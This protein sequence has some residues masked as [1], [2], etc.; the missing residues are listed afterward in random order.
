L[1]NDGLLDLFVTNGYV[2]DDRRSSYWY[3]FSKVAGGHKD[4]ISDAAHWP[5]MEGRSLSGYQLKKLWLNS[6]QWKFQQVAQA[7]GIN[8]TYDGRAVALVDLWNRGV[9]DVVVAHQRGPLLVYKNTTAA[10][11]D[12]I[13]FDLEGT[14]SNSSAIGTRVEVHW[15][16]QVQL[17]QVS[18]GMGFCSQNQR[19]LQFGLGHDAVVEKV[20]ITWPSGKSQTL[21]G[22]QT[23]TIHRLVEAA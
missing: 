10:D 14:E 5:A 17:Q 20:V 15:N 8:E 21:T 4:I 2:S 11:R 12:W 9:L 1:N 18:G 6:G 19:R 22:L 23:R 13:A 3:D 16:G 7:I